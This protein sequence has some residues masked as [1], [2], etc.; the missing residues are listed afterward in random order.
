M[1]TVKSDLSILL[2]S[3]NED[4]A[5]KGLAELFGETPPYTVTPTW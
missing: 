2:I 5:N 1:E 3:N 4:N